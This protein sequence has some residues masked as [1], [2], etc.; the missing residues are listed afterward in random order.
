MEGALSRTLFLDIETVPLYSSLD[1]LPEALRAHWLEKY[2]KKR[3]PDE[4]DENQ[5]FQDKS[6]IYAVF[7]RVVCIGL[8]WLGQQN[9]QW[10]WRE[11][12]LAHLDERQ[13]LAEFSQIW[14]DYFIDKDPSRA[15]VLCGHNLIGFDYVFL[16]KRFLLNALPLVPPWSESLLMPTWNLR[17]ARL[18]DTMHMW[19]FTSVER[20]R[21]IKLEVLAYILGFSFEKSLDHK[22]IQERFNLW[23]QTADRTAFEPV[24]TYC[25]EDVRITAKIYLKLIGRADLVSHI[26]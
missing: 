16:G 4:S 9:G 24:L 10:L 13:L 25:L 22:D 23:Q 15:P 26:T 6:G 18:I 19:S 1:E 2:D 7:S 21:Y 5:Y 11:K 20:E 12:V 14:R 17:T 8:G 3:K